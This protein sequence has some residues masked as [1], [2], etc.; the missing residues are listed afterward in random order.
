MIELTAEQKVR[1]QL[2]GSPFGDPQF[3]HEGEDVVRW[4]T[5]GNQ[6]DLHVTFHQEGERIAVKCAT[7]QTVLGYLPANHD[8]DQTAQALQEMRE[9]GHPHH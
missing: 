5:G 4:I 9:S 8:A 7:C 2:T 3:Q 1:Q 6:P